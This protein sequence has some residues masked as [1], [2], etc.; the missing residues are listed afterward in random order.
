LSI[1]HLVSN[2]HVVTEASLRTGAA[3]VMKD[4][5]GQKLGYFYFDDEP[6][7]R[8]AAKLHASQAALM[9]TANK[10]QIKSQGK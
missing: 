4:A 7:R 8:S 6:G 1:E 2:A 3:Y 10:S 5:S 9:K